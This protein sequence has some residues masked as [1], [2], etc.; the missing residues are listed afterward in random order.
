MDFL[1]LFGLRFDPRKH[2][3]PP[4]PTR[5]AE[6][7]IFKE[8]EPDTGHTVETFVNGAPIARTYDEAQEEGFPSVWVL[9]TEGAGRHR[10][11]KLTDQDLH[12]LAQKGLPADKA[13][14]IKKAWAQGK[15]N[16]E[17]VETFA[18]PVTKKPA[19]GFGLR[20]IETFTAAFSAAQNEEK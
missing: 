14:A 7:R 15:T 18:D 19:H 17:I 20:T 6:A 2:G 12:L 8:A 11:A 5:K 16:A 10:T 13:A 1:E 4:M 3:L 9:R